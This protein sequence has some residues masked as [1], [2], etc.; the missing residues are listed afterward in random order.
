MNFLKF[1]VLLAI[2]VACL[3]GMIYFFPVVASD[4]TNIT[5]INETVIT[6][7]NGTV[8][9]ENQSFTTEDMLEVYVNPY[10][11]KILITD[12]IGDKFI[13]SKTRWYETNKETYDKFTIN[14]TY[15]VYVFVDENNVYTIKDIFTQL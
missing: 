6:D 8:I 7:V 4:G 11:D 10:T 12:K 5:D 1:L 13:K 9:I 15:V 14:M 3:A 2:N